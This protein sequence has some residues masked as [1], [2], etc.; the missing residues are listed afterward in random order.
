[1]CNT[2]DSNNL[3]GSACYSKQVAEEAICD[4]REKN[5]DANLT[6][7]DLG[8][9]SLPHID[10]NFVAAASLKSR[11]SQQSTKDQSV[12]NH[13]LWRNFLDAVLEPR[14]I[15]NKDDIFEYLHY[16]HDLPPAV[17]D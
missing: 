5:P 13:S 10:D 2:L 1:M 16:R 12:H 7:R 6:A 4:L 17:L 8:Q 15:T 3:R 11:P 14:T 9:V